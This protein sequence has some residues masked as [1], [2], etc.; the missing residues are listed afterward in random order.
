MPPGTNQGTGNLH[1]AQLLAA[2]LAPK[3]EVRV[4]PAGKQQNACDCGVFAL[5]LGA[6]SAY[7]YFFW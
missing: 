3:T 2:K 6:E 5:L 1:T 7:F 4:A